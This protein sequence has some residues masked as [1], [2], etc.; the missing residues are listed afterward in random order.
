MAPF[1]PS[2]TPAFSSPSPSV[3][4]ARPT[5]QSSRSASIGLVALDMEQQ[6]AVLPLHDLLERRVELEVDPLRQ[7]DL[8][9]PVADLLV[10]MAQDAVAAIDQGHLAAELVED[11]GEFVGDIAAAGDHRALRHRLEVEHLVRGDAVLGAGHVRDHRPGAG[12]DQDRAGAD[13]R[14][15]RRASTWFGPVSVAR[16]ARI[17]TSWRSRMSV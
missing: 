14:C 16:W 9:Q 11:A 10:I 15:R 2:S 4:G 12:G 8:Q 17:S 3:F 5:A 1:L 6:R 7:R 13:L